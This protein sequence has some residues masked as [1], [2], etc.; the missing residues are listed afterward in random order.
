LRFKVDENLPKEVAQLLCENGHDAASVFDRIRIRGERNA[1]RFRHLPVDK[2]P[3]AHSDTCQQVP[4][5]RWAMNWRVA[6]RAFALPVDLSPVADVYH[7]DQEPIVVDLVEH[8]IIADANPPRIPSA[9]LLD[10]MR[11]RLVDQTADSRGYPFLVL[12]GDL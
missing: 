2:T 12:R 1:R 7:Q 5:L 3:A 6:L 4:G 10:S 9:E 8:A 11:S